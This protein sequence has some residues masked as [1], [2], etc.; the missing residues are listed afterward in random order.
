MEGVSERY[1]GYNIEAKRRYNRL[2]DLTRPL[3]LRNSA[4]HPY[5]LLYCASGR[6][7]VNVYTVK[8]STKRVRGVPQLFHFRETFSY[9]ATPPM[10]FAF[11][12]A[13]IP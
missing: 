13:L 9:P 12:P 7:N 2:R 3:S 10:I 5:C 8:P 11:G 1:T 4:K 6:N